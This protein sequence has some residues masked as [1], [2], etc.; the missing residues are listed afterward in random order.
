MKE[1][2]KTKMATNTKKQR[3]ATKKAMTQVT[4]SAMVAKKTKA[5]ATKT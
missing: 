4:V 1:K 2:R 3:E 5:P